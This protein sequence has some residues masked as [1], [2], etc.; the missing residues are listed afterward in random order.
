MLGLSSLGVV[1]TGGVITTALAIARGYLNEPR[2]GYSTPRKTGAPFALHD[3]LQPAAWMGVR[4]QAAH[5]QHTREGI[6]WEQCLGVVA[7]VSC[8]L[9]VGGAQSPRSRTFSHVTIPTF[10]A[11]TLYTLPRTQASNKPTNQ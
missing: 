6:F 9:Y 2:D 1:L 8:L 5:W 4:E 7:L 10:T 11:S 3:L